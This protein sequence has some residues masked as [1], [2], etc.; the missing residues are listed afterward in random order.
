MPTNEG[1]WRP[2]CNLCG[3]AHAAGAVDASG[4]HSLHEWSQVLV[5]HRA[6][7]LCESASVAPKVHGLQ[8]MPAPQLVY[9]RPDTLAS[10]IRSHKD[11]TPFV[12]ICGPVLSSSSGEHVWQIGVPEGLT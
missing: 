2:T 6:L 11:T 12:W 1:N 5:M 3:K 7:Q 10:D 4:H 8:T 9:M